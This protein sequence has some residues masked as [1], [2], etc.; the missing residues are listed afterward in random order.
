MR[1]LFK[2]LVLL[3]CLAAAAGCRSIPFKD[4]DYV[5]LAEVNPALMLEDF[6]AALAQKLEIINSIVFEF[7]WHSFAALGYTQL[8]LEQ[9]TFK[10]SCMNPVGIKLFELEGNRQKV[11]AVFVLKE[12]LERG[13]LPKA[14]GEDIRRIYFD[15]APDA[16]A[17]VKKEKYRIIFTQKTGRQTLKY[18]FA[19]QQRWLTEKHYYEG[20]RNLW[21]VYYYNYLNQEGKLY[22]S[23]LILSHHRF[24][25]NLVI[26]LKE[27]RLR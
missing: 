16:A 3:F 18:V 17:K 2:T 9:G 5:P 23:A 26:R 1:R 27:V 25:Y 21:S 11:D 12:L 10:V 4:I 6:K 20:R 14:V 19:G 7:K 13:D 22:P 8:D 24:G 15:M